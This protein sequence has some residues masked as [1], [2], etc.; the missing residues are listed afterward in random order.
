MKILFFIGSLRSGGKERRLVE[1]LTYLSDK[2][3]YELLVLMAYNEIAYPQFKNLGINYIIL[4]KKPQSIDI[5]LFVKVHTIVNQFKPDLIHT[6]GDMQ[7]FYMLPTTILKKIPIFNGQITDAAPNVK[8]RGIFSTFINFLNFKF[9]SVILANSYAGLKA[10]SV[11][12]ST[13]TKVIYNGMNLNRFTSLSDKNEIKSKYNICTKYSVI[14]TASFS[15]LKDYERFCQV[16]EYV[17][18][19][20]NDITFIGVGAIYKNDPSYEKACKYAHNNPFILF[21]G[22]VSEVESL[23]NA[24]DIGVLFSNVLHHGEGISNSIIEYMALGKPVIVDDCGGTKE[25]VND[26]ENG[27]KI[28]HLSIEEIGDKIIALIH[29][30][31]KREAMGNNGKKTVLTLFTLEKMGN[32]FEKLYKETISLKKIN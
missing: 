17:T 10:Y 14:M 22:R 25:F 16:A 32:E 19:K 24:C 29:N 13:K 26:E 21:P 1:L 23:I 11:E 7:T 9:S 18:H 5:K 28:T 15:P 30:P 20:M 3:E 31:E 2:K 4:D 6:W 8:D 12:K 27:Y